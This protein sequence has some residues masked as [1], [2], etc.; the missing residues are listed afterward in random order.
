MHC[1]DCSEQIS[2]YLDGLLDQEQVTRLQAHLAHCEACRAEW[3][4]V[5]WLSSILEAE[6]AAAPAPDFA[7]RVNLRLQQ[8]E[9]RRRR[10]HGG[11]GVLLGSVGLWGAAAVAVA[12]LFVVLWQPSLR[13]VWLDVCRPLAG[14]ASSILAVLGRALYSVVHE[15]FQQP[16][17]LLLSG[18][19]ILALGLI[20]LWT[21][22]VLRPRALVLQMNAKNRLQIRRY[23][24]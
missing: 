1:S 20:A 15:L 21:R 23:L 18:Y 9:T 24:R 13:I 14:K 4:A 22:I 11:I 7:A 10:V 17:W 6:P 2:L 19:A 3:E 5:H 16:S 12:L 8:R